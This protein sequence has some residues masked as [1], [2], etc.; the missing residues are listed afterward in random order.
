MTT[1]V[2]TNCNV[3]MNT[4]SVLKVNNNERNEGYLVSNQQTNPPLLHIKV[5]NF[6]KDESQVKILHIQGPPKGRGNNKFNKCKFLQVMTS[7]AGGLY[8]NMKVTYWF[9]FHQAQQLS[10]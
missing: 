7:Q 6:R 5:N 3:K 2:M 4:L 10:N 1:M 8:R 9:P